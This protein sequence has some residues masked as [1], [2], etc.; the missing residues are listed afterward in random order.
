MLTV[1]NG[2]M[3]R[4]RAQLRIAVAP[5]GTK[6]LFSRIM[7]DTVVSVLIFFTVWAPESLAQMD[8]QTGSQTRLRADEVGI[9]VSNLSFSAIAE[10]SVVLALKQSGAGWIRI[11]LYWGWLE[12]SPGKIDWSSVDQG[13][14]ALRSAGISALV[15]LNGPVPCWALDSVHARGCRL[16]QQIMPNSAVQP[17][18]DFVSAAVRRYG[19]QVHYW[20]IWNEPD[21]LSSIDESNPTQRLMDY[22]DN[23]LSPGARAVHLADPSAKVVAPAFAAIPS[24]NSAPGRELQTALSVVLGGGVGSNIDIVSLHSY[25][26]YSAVSKL[27]SAHKGLARLGIADRPLWVTELGISGSLLPS[28]RVRHREATF[29]LSETNAILSTHAAKKIFWFALTDSPTP[30]GDHADDYGLISNEDYHSYAWRP[31]AAY[32]ELKRWIRAGCL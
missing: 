25:Y 15:T 12:Q 10:P 32:M 20:E 3:T 7:A 21:L 22:R 16:P 14:A 8:C 13:L 27:R 4:V 23:V 19:K 5:G 31:R 17:W 9:N 30:A 29:L 28:R 26:P 6:M 1:P 11:N 2:Y 24:G 18:T